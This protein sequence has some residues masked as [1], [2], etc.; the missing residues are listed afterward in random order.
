[1]PIYTL[2]QFNLLA[3]VYLGSASPED[4]GYV[5]TWTNVP[6]QKYVLQNSGAAFNVVYWT[7]GGFLVEWRFPRTVAPFDDTIQAMS[8]LGYVCTAGNVDVFYRIHD[9]EFKHEGFPNEYAVM[10]GHKTNGLGFPWRPAT[11]TADPYPY[12]DLEQALGDI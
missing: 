2:P 1:M 6:A 9:F 8:D 4:Q 12:G 5:P 11:H 10:M 7:S 3:D